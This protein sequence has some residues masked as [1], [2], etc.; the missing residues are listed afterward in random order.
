MQNSETDNG[1]KRHV[2]NYA[3]TSRDLEREKADPEGSP[4][5]GFATICTVE[6][7]IT[8]DHDRIS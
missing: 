2:E 6:K 4:S 1:D 3:I 5:V 7:P 8:V